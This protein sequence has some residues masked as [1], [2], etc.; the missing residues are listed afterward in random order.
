MILTIFAEFDRAIIQVNV[1][2]NGVIDSKWL[3]K[4]N[5]QKLCQQH[6][7]HNNLPGN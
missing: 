2:S 4:Q 7:Y 1:A 5:D 3:E 6:R